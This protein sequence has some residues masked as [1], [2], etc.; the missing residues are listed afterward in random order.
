M[1]GVGKVKSEGRVTGTR[2]GG[3]DMARREIVL[4]QR[5]PQRAQMALAPNA[6]LACRSDLSQHYT[7][8][9]L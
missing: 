3:V 2:V 4:Q 8:I 9:I 6:T 7:E 1:V 5:I